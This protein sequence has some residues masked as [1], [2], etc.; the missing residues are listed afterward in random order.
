MGWDAHPREPLAVAIA[1]AAEAISYADLGEEAL[2]AA[3]RAVGASNAL[4]YRYDEAGVVRGV[5]GTL[6]PAIPSY[7]REMF[8]QD[9]VQHHLI[10]LGNP[11]GGAD[12][13]RHGPA[14]LPEERG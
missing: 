4:L 7:A 12:H 9:P 8:E 10:A 14:R 1:A 3:V 2:G 11:P 13:P 6:A 5:A